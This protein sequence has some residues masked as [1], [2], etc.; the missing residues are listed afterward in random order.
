MA[1]LP[2][3]A[4]SEERSAALEQAEVLLLAKLVASSSLLGFVGGAGC[5]VCL[6]EK[7]KQHQRVEGKKM[8]SKMRSS[9]T[10]PHCTREGRRGHV[11][12]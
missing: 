12:P 7:G 1:Q 3:N 10:A 11:V 4:G 9:C 8:K 5:W 2:Q 6:R